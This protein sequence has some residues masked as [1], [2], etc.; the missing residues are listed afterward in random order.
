MRPNRLVTAVAGILMVLGALAAAAF[1]AAASGSRHAAAHADVKAKPSTEAFGQA[2]R[3]LWE[4]HITWTRLFIV[5]V[6]ADLPDTEAT[7]DRLLRNQTDIGDAI[8]PYYGDAA[9]TQLT[10]LLRDH[11]LTA[12][13]LLAAAKVR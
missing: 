2:M 3:K 12:A 5:S 9:G 6:D 1:P 8:K 4:D 11:I 10:G 7:T 13:G